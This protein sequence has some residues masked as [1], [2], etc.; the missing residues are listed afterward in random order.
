MADTAYQAFETLGKSGL[1]STGLARAQR[2]LGEDALAR[3]TFRAAAA[4][5]EERAA[6]LVERDG[7]PRAGRARLQT[8]EAWLEAGE[9]ARAQGLIADLIPFAASLPPDERARLGFVLARGGHVGRARA[10]L[11]ALPESPAARALKAVIDRV[12]VAEAAAELEAAICARGPE[13]AKPW[14]DSAWWDVIRWMRG[15]GGAG[16]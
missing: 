8:A 5:L 14:A 4:R 16:G 13:D 12:E 3:E 2:E 1:P 6:A 11:S 7:L 15:G 9:P 10:V